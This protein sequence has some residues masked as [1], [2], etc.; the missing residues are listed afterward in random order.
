[1]E[2]ERKVNKCHLE[3]NEFS[4]T[5]LNGSILLLCNSSRPSRDEWL[6]A[7]PR[8]LVAGFVKTDIEFQPKG[9]Y[10]K[11][12]FGGNEGDFAFRGQLVTQMW[13]SSLFQ[14]H[15][16][17]M[18]GGRLASDGIRDALSSDMVA[19]FCRGLPAKLVVKVMSGIGSFF[20]KALNSTNKASN[21]LSAVGVREELF[22][23]GSA[24]LAERFV[25]H[26][27]QLM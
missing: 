5:K 20:E 26:N 18:L 15:I 19:Q 14:Y 10:C 22:E 3:S 11:R 23:L 12:G 1:M 25:H 8:A 4:L 21:K 16:F 9:T 24:M 2:M 27:I 13:E 7:L 6:Q 17:Q